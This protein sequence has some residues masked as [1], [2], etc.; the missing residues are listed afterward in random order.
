MRASETMDDEHLQARD[1]ETAEEPEPGLV[2]IFSSGRPA[3]AVLPLA[4][5]SIE[6]GRGEVLGVTIDDKRMSRAHARISFDRGAWTLEDLRSRNGSA[7][8]GREIEAGAPSP[9]GALVR[10]GGS[11]FLLAAD[12]RPYRSGVARSADT[13]MGPALLRAFSAIARAARSGGVLHITGESGSGKELAARAFHDAGPAADGPFV[14]VN[15]AT[16]R[17][18]LAEAMLFGS[19]KGFY[20]GAPGGPGFLQ[21]ASGGTLFLD[22]VA[23]LDT[24]V[25]AKLLRALQTRE[26]LPLGA[27]RPE[28]VDLRFCSATHA[29]LRSLVATGKMR[30]DLYYRIATPAVRLPPLR[31][32][33]EEIPWLIEQA[34]HRLEG[35][36]KPPA[37]HV[38]FVEACLLRPWPGN[39]RE[40]TA[41]VKSAA[42]WA[43]EDGGVLLARH[44]DPRA[45]TAANAP[46]PDGPPPPSRPAPSPGG[47][48]DDATIE[49]ALRAA[50]NNKSAAARALGMHR[51]QLVRWL[52]KRGGAAKQDRDPH[53]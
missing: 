49:E 27:T 26:V 19:R 15:A 42:Q 48:V 50:G 46:E 39:V 45:G 41:E 36:V 30:D 17:A 25:Q 33:T 5:G 12:T 22:E 24:A 23:E 38:S 43:V 9:A 4:R 47:K 21:A 14:A 44:L 11:L 29:D 13:V 6:V 35:A 10:T 8:D 2:L 53:E 34:L 51:T 40:L 3:A 16:L 37:L 52:E 20:T 18:D 31:E 7:A 1:V 32:R 28:R